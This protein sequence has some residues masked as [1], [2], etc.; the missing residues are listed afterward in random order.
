MTALTLL[1]IPL[2]GLL[3]AF[4][5]GHQKFLATYLNYSYVKSISLNASVFTLTGFFV[6]FALFD[7]SN[8]QFQFVEQY[9]DIGYFDLCLGVDGLSL[10]F[11]LL[12]SI[13]MPVSLL[14]N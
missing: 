12:T 5:H 4:A 2:S 3:L 13:I 1:S 11:V 9:Y 7:L 14:S 8:K 10:Y 6:M